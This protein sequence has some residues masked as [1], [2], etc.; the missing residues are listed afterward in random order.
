MSR[1]QNK[2]SP[3]H[4]PDHHPVSTSL[5]HPPRSTAPSLFK[6]PAW[7]PFRTTSLHVPLV[8][9]PVRSPLPHTPHISSPNQCPPAARAHTIASCSAAVSISHHPLPVFLLLPTCNSVPYPNTTHPP[10]HPHLRPLKRH[11]TFLPDRPGRGK[12]R[13]CGS[14]DFKCVKCGCCWRRK[15]AFYPYTRQPKFVSPD[16]NWYIA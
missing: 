5:L 1:Y 10:D 7:Q 16:S 9:L 2:H 13:T 15:S 11:L 8:Y 3:T 6:L 12:M 14:A 4:H